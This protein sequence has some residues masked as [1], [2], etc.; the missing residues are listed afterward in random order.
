M[1]A[2]VEACNRDTEFGRSAL[3]WSGAIEFEVR[4]CPAPFDKPVVFR[5]GGED[6]RWTSFEVDA[7]TGLSSD[8]LFSLSATHAVWKSVIRQEI[9]PLKGLI[10]GRLRVAGQLSAVLQWR[11]AILVVTR[12]AVN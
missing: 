10:Q 2:L 12:I 8:A 11:A 9:N 6:G 1:A 4:D 7:T 3:G 5:L